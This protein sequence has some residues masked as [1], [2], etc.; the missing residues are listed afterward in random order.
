VHAPDPGG[1]FG[2]KGFPKYEPLVAAIALE[3]GHPVRLVL[4]LEETFQA[5]RRA[6]AR[7]RL[8]TGFSSEGDLLFIDA[9]DDFLMGAYADIAP[10]VISKA[11]YFAAGPYK[12][13]SVR[14]IARG[15]VSH[16]TPSTAFRGFGAPQ[17]A[18]AIE[19]QTPAHST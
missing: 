11:T 19:S 2:G 4:S 8:R 15:L 10:R 14:A 16:T 5:V 6:A 9:V 1:G 7:I 12:V 3:L 13:G 17:V 18:W